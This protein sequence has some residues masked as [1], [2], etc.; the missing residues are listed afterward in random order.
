MEWRMDK[1]QLIM[2]TLSLLTLASALALYLWRL[3]ED[4]A[5]RLSLVIKRKLRL[6]K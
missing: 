2:Q 1:G 3:D 6:T 4:E 5:A